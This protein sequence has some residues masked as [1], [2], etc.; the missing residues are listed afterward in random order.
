MRRSPVLSA[1]RCVS[2]F[3]QPLL[4]L[5]FRLSQDIITGLDGVLFN[6]L[7]SNLTW[8][9][10]LYDTDQDGHLTKDEILQVSEALLFIFR[11]EPGD[12]YLGSVSNTLQNLF[13]FG[14]TTKPEVPASPPS[15]DDPADSAVDANRPFLSLATFRMCIL[16]DAL[17]EDFFESDLTATWRLEVLVPEE[18][19]KPQTVAGGWWRGVVSAVVTDENKVRLALS[20]SHRSK[21][22]FLLA[23]RN[24]STD[25]PM[26]S[27]SA[28]TF[29]PSSSVRRSSSP[30]DLAPN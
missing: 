17:L 29:R 7:M 19:P 21:L 14:E 15:S 6:D 28:S 5:T 23:R 8:L 22:T 11:N 20:P 1:S 16:A 13:E 26:K 4:S 18:K 30:L 12:R 10:N 24:A 3:L 2:C 27:E 9:F 25:W